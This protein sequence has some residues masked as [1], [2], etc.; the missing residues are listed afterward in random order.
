M[1]VYEKEKYAK[2]LN[3]LYVI[4]ENNNDKIF[5]YIDK[6]I[7]KINKMPNTD[8]INIWLQRL[9]IK[10]DRNRV[11]N[12]HLCQKIYNNSTELFDTTWISSRKIKVDEKL[13]IDEEEIDSNP[14]NHCSAG[15][16]LDPSL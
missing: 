12:T 11:Y 4:V 8:Y 14:S 2:V 3:E 1:T 10:L 15:E 16:E 9:T 5:N 13:I 6:L 7:D